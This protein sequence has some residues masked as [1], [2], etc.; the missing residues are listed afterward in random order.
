MGKSPGGSPL[1]PQ[2]PQP[3]GPQVPYGEASPAM[4]IEAQY[5]SYL[6]TDGQQMATGLTPQ[7]MLGAEGLKD[8]AALQAEANRKALAAA[9]AAA[10]P[11]Q[12]Q[13]HGLDAMNERDY[14]LRRWFATEEERD[15]ALGHRYAGRGG[16]YD[17]GIG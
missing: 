9:L 6:P 10:P 14:G 1:P 16:G 3:G 13:R 7:M 12:D 4:P 11:Q 2:M 8:P 17:R 15:E 5:M